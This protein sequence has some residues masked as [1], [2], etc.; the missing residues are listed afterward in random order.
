M[1]VELEQA[2]EKFESVRNRVFDALGVQD[3]WRD[4]KGNVP[5]GIGRTRIP[6]TAITIV[7]WRDCWAGYEI[8]VEQKWVHIVLTAGWMFSKPTREVRDPQSVVVVVAGSDAELKW[9]KE[10]SF[11]AFADDVSKALAAR[12]RRL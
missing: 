11:S 2:K 9:T 4:Y 10:K 1:S 5:L 8:E 12:A 3:K 6:G 7:E